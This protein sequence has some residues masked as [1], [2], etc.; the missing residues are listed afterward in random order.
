VSLPALR[1][2]IR[3]GFVVEAEKISKAL[4]SSA[5]V[6]VERAY[7]QLLKFE[8]PDIPAAASSDIGAVRLLVLN[9][10][11]LNR[12]R[13]P[14]RALAVLSE[15]QD[16]AKN[17]DVLAD[18]FFETARVYAW[19]G[20]EKLAA[21]NLTQIL[22]FDAEKP[23]RFLVLYRLGNLYAEVERF[24]LAQQY[25]NLAQAISK[26]MER[27]VYYA[28]FQECAARVDMA[29]GGS[30]D[31]QRAWLRKNSAKL[32]SYLKFR[33][34]VLEIEDALAKQDVAKLNLFLGEP[35]PPVVIPA[36]AG[37]S[38]SKRDRVVQ[39]GPRLRGDNSLIGTFEGQFL[40]VL[41]AR[42]DLIKKQPLPA[43]EKLKAARDWFADED[44]ATRL[45]QARIF[46]AQAYVM[47]GQHDLAALE[48]D[49]IRGYCASRQMI[50]QQ[51]KVERAFA[52]L[53]LTL[54]PIIETNR[55]SAEGAWKDAQAYVLI[56]RL[57]E[58]GQAQV[59][60][61]H[62]NARGRQVAYKKMKGADL[63]ALSREV[64]LANAA[65]VDGVAKILACGKTADGSLYM[66]QEFVAGRSLRKLIDANQARF[67]HAQQAQT[68]LSALHKAKI[69]HGDVKPENVIVD[70]EGQV[71]LV[72]FGLAQIAGVPL[73]GATPRYAAPA[74]PARFRKPAWR[75][76]YALGL[77][78]IECC[79]GVLPERHD[80]VADMFGVSSGLKNVVNALQV[81]SQTKKEI[82]RMLA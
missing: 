42:F 44:L 15:A 2:A 37:I 58:G 47:K 68:I 73:R 34:E 10:A 38:L 25:L 56:K 57:G 31:T 22:A 11:Q 78:M 21:E 49:Q 48:L 55:N 29:S 62:D 5:D 51:E 23:I 59:Y 39:L 64:R 66:V 20:N 75:D 76:T 32:P 6:A 28:Q 43:I 3:F 18:V 4:R 60:L 13:D 52:D 50:L 40:N 7:L 81:D 9:A 65:Q 26:S 77:V 63:E 27:S 16:K 71:T 45:I 30:G 35:L 82:L 14:L 12:A 41:S 54:N 53:N 70:E 46:L 72:D 61:A 19:L 69:V 67:L 33:S 36:K 74:W 1:K 8:K 17:A 24:V 79:G 80:R